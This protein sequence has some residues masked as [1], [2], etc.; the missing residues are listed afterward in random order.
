MTEQ[1]YVVDQLDN[2]I[3][4]LVSDAGRTI[5]LPKSRLP[6]QIAEGSVLRVPLDRGGALDWPAAWIDKEETRR[7]RNEAENMLRDLRDRDPGGD[8]K[9]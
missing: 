8:V 4:T 1:V 7:R 6:L 5:T 9:L 3:A 2:D